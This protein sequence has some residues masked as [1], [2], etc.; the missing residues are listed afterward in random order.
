METV[1]CGKMSTG[2]DVIVI[3]LFFRSVEDGYGEVI[4]FFF[5]KMGIVHYFGLFEHNNKLHIHYGVCVDGVMRPWF[6]SNDDIDSNVSDEI[7]IYENDPESVCECDGYLATNYSVYKTCFE[8]FDKLYS[9]VQLLLS[10]QDLER[11][12]KHICDEFYDDY[13]NDY[14]EWKQC[15][16]VR[17][18]LVLMSL[19]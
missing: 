10:K 8:D 9:D 15:S 11:F 1:F 3:N 2:I 6:I 16:V 4:Y 19:L 14:K 5:H 12:K 13:I 7:G 18:Q 17:S